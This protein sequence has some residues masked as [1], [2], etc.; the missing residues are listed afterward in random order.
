MFIIFDILCLLEITI[1]VLDESGINESALA[2]LP[3]SLQRPC[4]G[5]VCQRDSVVLGLG[6]AHVLGIKGQQQQKLLS[7]LKERLRWLPTV[8]EI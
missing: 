5:N 4:S 7:H 8:F 1:K 6:H 3:C 2:C